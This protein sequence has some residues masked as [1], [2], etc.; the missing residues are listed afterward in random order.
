[1]NPLIPP[2]SLRA[3][4]DSVFRQP[5]YQWGEPDVALSW[6]R[7]TWSALLAWLAG[8]RD[9]SPLLYRLFIALLVV[10]LVGILL[11]AALILY[12]TARRAEESADPAIAP[13][14]PSRGAA[15][16]RNEA[17]RLAR[18]GQFAEAVQVAFVALARRLDELGL[19]QYHPSKTPAECARDARLADADRPRLRRLVAELY[20]AAFAG[21]PFGA[22]EYGQWMAAADGE[23]HAPAY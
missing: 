14:A 10:I 16:F 2:D 3:A 17:D 8:L 23:W 22:E 19:L 4:L 18:A 20:R 12:R 9:V 13:A 7:R 1:M 11:H 15:W 5:A 6:L 21:A